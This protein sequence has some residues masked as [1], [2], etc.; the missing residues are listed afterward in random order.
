MRCAVPHRPPSTDVSCDFKTRTLACDNPQHTGH[1]TRKGVANKQNQ[2]TSISNCW[3]LKKL[4]PA[5]GRI[6]R[7]QLCK[8]P[9]TL[10]QP[11]PPHAH[12]GLGPARGKPKRP[13]ATQTSGQAAS[14]HHVRP[15][16]SPFHV[17]PDDKRCSPAEQ[18]EGS[19]L[20]PGLE[21]EG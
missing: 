5:I 10:S 6:L 19:A 9:P 16:A 11:P 14:L 13:P 3:P 18:P 12:A 17:T 8:A 2:D 21:S 4:V 20:T 7:D 1:L 15:C